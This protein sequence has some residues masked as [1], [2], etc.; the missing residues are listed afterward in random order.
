MDWVSFGLRVFCWVPRIGERLLADKERLVDLML[1]GV[2]PLRAVYGLPDVVRSKSPCSSFRPKTVH[3][4]CHANCV[5]T[6]NTRHERRWCLSWDFCWE[7]I[8]LRCQSC[9]LAGSGTLLG[10]VTRSFIFSLK[11]R[12]D[13][14]ICF[15]ISLQVSCQDFVTGFPAYTLGL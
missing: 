6:R 14:E 15:L 5:S 3:I 12:S 11:S 9:F 1:V 7:N 13:E 8:S 2:A 10:S 4:V